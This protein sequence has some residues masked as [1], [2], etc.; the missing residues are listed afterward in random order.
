MKFAEPANYS[1]RLKIT[2]GAVFMAMG[3]WIMLGSV[4]PPQLDNKLKVIM[5]FVFIFY[6][7]YRM[8]HGTYRKNLRKHYADD[9]DE[10]EGT[11]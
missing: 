2:L 6:G 3:L 11:K 7:I 5:G 10:G 9:T 4:F 8:V 1:E